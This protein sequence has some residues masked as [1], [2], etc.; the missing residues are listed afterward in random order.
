MCFLLIFVRPVFT[1]ISRSH[2]DPF[3]CSTAVTHTK[4]AQKVANNK[5]DVLW[6]QDASV[7][8]ASCSAKVCIE[9]MCIGR[10]YTS[11]MAH[12]EQMPYDVYIRRLAAKGLTERFSSIY[13]NLSSK[14]NSINWPITVCSAFP[15][16]KLLSPDFYKRDASPKRRFQQWND[17]FERYLAHQGRLI[18][19]PTNQLHWNFIDRCRAPDSY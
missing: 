11:C 16:R 13:S 8:S 18:E 9:P 1:K 4:V 15:F 17:S 6:C 19:S 14:T 5:A 3:Q 2:T 12:G 10:I 7:N